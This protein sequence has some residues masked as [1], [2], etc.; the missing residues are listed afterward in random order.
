MKPSFD[1]SFYF[2]IHAVVHAFSLPSASK[3]LQKQLRPAPAHSRHVHVAPGQ[4][5][6]GRH[7]AGLAGCTRSPC[8]SGGL[9]GCMCDCVGVVQLVHC[10]V[11]RSETRLE[12]AASHFHG[13]CTAH[14][15]TICISAPHCSPASP[16]EPCPLVTPARLTSRPSSPSSEG[17]KT[18]CRRGSPGPPASTT[19]PPPATAGRRRLQTRRAAPPRSAAFRHGHL[20]A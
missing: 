4:G 1:E 7:V 2:I 20:D 3:Q 14:F 5:G 10:H 18:A 17:H 8:M 9:T 11:C 16:P 12:L 13:R 6:D 15:A 19:S